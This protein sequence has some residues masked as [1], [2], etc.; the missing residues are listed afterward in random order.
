MKK[1]L[2]VGL[3]VLLS[4]GVAFAGESGSACIGSGC[5]NVQGSF[6]IDTL[7]IGGGIDAAGKIV[8]GGAA[9][10]ISGAGGATIGQA[11]GQ[12]ST[13]SFKT[14]GVVSTTH[15]DNI[16]EKDVNGFGNHKFGAPLG[17]DRNQFNSNPPNANSGWYLVKGGYDQPNYGWVTKTLAGGTAGAELTTRGGGITN[18]TAYSDSAPGQKLV[19]S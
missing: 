6:N 17:Y 16:Y 19:G 14:W 3:A 12:I 18:T 9:G 2:V 10:G 13:F 11:S 4:A 7:A 1:I 8:P 5:G 15:Y